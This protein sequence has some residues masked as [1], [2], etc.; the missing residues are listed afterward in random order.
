MQVVRMSCGDEM[1]RKA[2]RLESKS[3]QQRLTLKFPEAAMDH[4]RLAGKKR[5]NPPEHTPPQPTPTKSKRDNKLR[6]LDDIQPR[7]SEFRQIEASL[8]I[9]L[10]PM[11]IGNPLNGIQ[12]MLDSMLMR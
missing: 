11:F 12:D 8:D 6:A 1:S 7:S 3:L 9:T 2:S 10:P 5:K 4:S